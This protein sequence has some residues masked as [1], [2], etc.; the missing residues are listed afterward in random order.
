MSF[1]G[2]FQRSP[3]LI[4]KT[5]EAHAVGRTTC[6]TGRKDKETFKKDPLPMKGRAA[7]PNCFLAASFFS[8]LS[9]CLLTRCLVEDLTSRPGW[10]IIVCLVRG[11]C[12]LPISCFM[13]FVYGFGVIL[14]KK[15]R[16][17]DFW[18]CFKVCFDH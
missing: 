14:S 6:G 9:A 12:G 1:Y 10:F 15:R 4:F 2:V 17:V 18:C 16:G 13:S 3:V 11:L 5:C 8:R 7:L